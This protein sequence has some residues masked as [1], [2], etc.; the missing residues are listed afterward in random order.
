MQPLW[1]FLKAVLHT[2]QKLGKSVMPAQFADQFAVV[3]QTHI[4]CIWRFGVASRQER[5]VNNVTLPRVQHE[6]CAKHMCAAARLLALVIGLTPWRQ[7]IRGQH[8]HRLPTV[9]VQRRRAG[10]QPSLSPT[11]SRWERARAIPAAAAASAAP[12]GTP[13]LPT[14]RIVSAGV[15]STTQSC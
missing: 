8:A 6:C 3:I 14:Q 15:C 13:H 7:V 12:S 1:P 11:G 5:P 4:T 2:P 10:E 9:G